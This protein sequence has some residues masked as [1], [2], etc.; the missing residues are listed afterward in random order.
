MRKFY[1]DIFL[2]ILFLLVMSFH[3]IPKSFHEIFGLILPL[4][5][6]GH[7]IWNWKAFKNQKKRLTKIIDVALILC[8]IVV[9]FSGIC[10][11]NFIFRGM[12]DIELQRNITIHQLHVSIPFVMMI[13]IG[14]HLGFNWQSIR[15]RFKNLIGLNVPSI[16]NK[17]LIVIMVSIGIYGSFLN[18]IGDRL[19]MK[20]IFFTDAV[21]LP[22]EL[23]LL[24]MIGIFSIYVLIGYLISSKIFR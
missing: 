10:I 8:L 7:F 13:L 2:M 1:L 3:F 4:A 19:M 21:N 17:I 16:L 23:F 12:I 11:S 5:M 18:K 6:I 24:L 15:Q 20:H 9:T 14:L 22:F